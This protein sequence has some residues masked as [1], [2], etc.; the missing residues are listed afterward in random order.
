[1]SKGV[2]IIKKNLFIYNGEEYDFDR[3]N[4]ISNSL[5]SNLKII[6]LEEDLYAK[7]FTSKV[8]RNQIYQFVEYK[9]NDDL[10]QNGDILYDFEKSN[11]IIN[12]YYIKGAKRIEKLSEKAKNIEVKPIQFIVKDIMRKILNNQNF[13]CRILLKYQEYYY[14]IS[15]KN[16]LFYNGL[17]TE[18]KDFAVNK[19]IENNDLG[20]IYFDYS[21]EDDLFFLDKFEIIKIN[22]GELINEKIYEKQRFYSRKILSEKAGQYK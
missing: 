3:V 19:I 8:K 4:E 11:N 1:M 12:I 18:N 15:L 17:V 16:G 7:Q 9:I 10:M 22:L 5:K 14:Y 20:E 21:I 2:V 6:I 13:T